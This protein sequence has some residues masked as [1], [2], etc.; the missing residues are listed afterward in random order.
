MNYPAWGT[1]MGQPFGVI[2]YCNTGFTFDRNKIHEYQ[3]YWPKEETGLARDVYIGFKYQ[4]VEYARRFLTLNF[5]AAFQDVP[6]AHHIW[7]LDTI[8]DCTKEEGTFPFI[9]FPNGSQE[10]PKFGDLIIYPYSKEQRFG[11]V[12]VIIN[13]NLEEKF[14]D[15]GEQN[16]EE[17]GWECPEYARRLIMKIENGQYFITNQRIGKPYDNWDIKEEIFGWKRINFNQN[18]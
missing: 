8:E 14:V 2:A 13:V 18:K 1:V 4:C 17:A 5:K 3:T 15:I 6:H 7:A 10:P 12:G 11:H 16:Y 9:N